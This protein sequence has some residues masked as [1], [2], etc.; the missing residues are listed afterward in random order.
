MSATYTLFTLLNIAVAIIL[1]CL[2]VLIMIS[3][4]LYIEDVSQS[5]PE[6]PII[7]T[8]PEIRSDKEPK[9]KFTDIVVNLTTT[10]S[11]FMNFPSASDLDE[12]RKVKIDMD[13][14]ES[15]SKLDV[16]I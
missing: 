10:L 5:T 11:N 7:P 15:I 3:S 1:V 14:G 13:G 2:N 16:L 9:F 12:V 6:I 4:D 8:I